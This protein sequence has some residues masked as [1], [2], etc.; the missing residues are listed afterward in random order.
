MSRRRK[1]KNPKPLPEDRRTPKSLRALRLSF[2]IAIVGSL[3]ALVCAKKSA[4]QPIVVKESAR[5]E[6]KRSDGAPKL[7]T[8]SGRVV[9]DNGV[10]IP[11]VLVNRQSIG[12]PNYDYLIRDAGG[13][14]RRIV[15]G[16]NSFAIKDAL[17]NGKIVEDAINGHDIQAFVDCWTSRTPATVHD[18]DAPICCHCIN[19]SRNKY[20]GNHPP[21]VSWRSGLFLIPMLMGETPPGHG[22]PI[23]ERFRKSGNVSRVP[24]TTSKA[25]GESMG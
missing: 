15:S 23:P 12:N 20:T 11:D 19:L 22:E 13:K 17:R 4:N 8:I 7:L 2:A 6:A 10:G 25:A 5:S 9:D 16:H 24:K 14:P 18:P 1:I 21:R 3:L